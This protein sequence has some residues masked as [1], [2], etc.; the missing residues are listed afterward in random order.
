MSI[1]ASAV[2]LQPM[3]LAA[4]SGSSIPRMGLTGQRTFFTSASLRSN[5]EASSIRPA[6]LLKAQTSPSTSKSVTRAFSTSRILAL[7][8][9]YF[10]RPAS[11]TRDA[12]GRGGGR[13]GGSW[14]Q[15]FRERL[16]NLPP[17]YV[18][19]GLIGVNV[20]IYGLWQYA[21]TSWTRFRDPSLYY[22]MSRNFIVS[23]ANFAAG[24]L[25][26]SLSSTWKV[27]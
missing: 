8:E 18:V 23:E 6:A 9:S 16:D 12:Y 26:V 27:G 15:N 4:F 2:R 1:F 14:W 20:A 11:K 17:M 10:Q 25:Y 3:R 5:L 21:N 22:W 7:R 13:G 24:R 19:Y